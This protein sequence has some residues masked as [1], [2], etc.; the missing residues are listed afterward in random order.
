MS[1]VASAPGVASARVW[2]LMSRGREPRGGR[3]VPEGVRVDYPR[4]R[5]LP[6]QPA[7]KEG[8]ARNPYPGLWRGASTKSCR[9]TPLV[10]VP[11]RS[12]RSWFSNALPRS[13]CALPT[14]STNVST[15]L[16]VSSDPRPKSI[17]RPRLAPRRL[18]G[19][20]TGNRRRFHPRR[21]DP[22]LVRTEP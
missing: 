16:G 21:L 4:R 7:T 18:R 11:R 14:I 10:R 15:E 12:S 2:H 17:E 6:V 19:T 13:G 3:A 20:A 1:A 22:V 9:E 8:R 5:G